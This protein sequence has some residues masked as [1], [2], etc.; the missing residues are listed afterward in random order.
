MA[1]ERLVSDLMTRDVV[2]MY[3]EDNLE[4]VSRELG[5]LRFRHMPVVDD[6]KLV[7]LLSQRDL[8][9]ATISGAGQSAASRARDARFLEETFVRD[10]MR[11][12]VV[13]IGPNEA[14]RAAAR[15]ML[16]AHIGALPVVEADG[17][18]VGIITE[19]DITRM[20]AEL[21]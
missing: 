5:R 16:D 9:Q 21:L 12:E 13:T 4:R 15:K 7:G 14:V 8:L 1:Q 11:T 17:T 19:N 6:G 18:L 10:V 3:E 2:T 20:A